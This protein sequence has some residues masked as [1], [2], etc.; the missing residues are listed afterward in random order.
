M[1]ESSYKTKQRQLILDCL[2]QNKDKSY[3]VDEIVDMLKQSGS[4]VGR[5]TVYRYCDALSKNGTLRF[6]LQGNGKS[7]TYQYIE[8]HEDCHEH[9]HLKCVKCG[10]FIHLGC[11]F[12]SGVCEHIMQHHGFTVDNSKTTLMGLCSECAQKEENNVTD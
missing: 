10:K 6:F 12:M 5:T 4:M 3:T 1:S 7:T 2:S 9:M 11:D 8:H